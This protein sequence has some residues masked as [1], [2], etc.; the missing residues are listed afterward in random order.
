MNCCDEYG[1]CREGYNC[2]VRTATAANPLQV[3]APTFSWRSYAKHL[4][5][6]LPVAFIC[7]FCLALALVWGTP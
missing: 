7:L 3:A 2:P 1:K 5:K 4:A 6:R